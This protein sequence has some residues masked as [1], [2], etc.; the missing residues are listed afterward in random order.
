MLLAVRLSLSFPVLL[1]AIPLYRKDYGYADADERE[2]P[3][4][5]WMSD[6]GITSNFPIHLFDSLLPDRPT[7]GFSLDAFDEKRSTSDPSDPEA[8]VELPSAAGQGLVRPIR[9]F[10]GLG[11]FAAA[12]LNS[13]RNWQDSLQSVLPGYR[14]RIVH[15]A[16]DESEGGLNLSM[17]PELIESLGRYGDIA[18]S[19]LLDFEFSEHRW[20][21]LLSTYSA[22]EQCLEELIEDYE[23]GFADDIAA[24]E[25]KSYK[26]S[27]KRRQ[28]ISSRVESLLGV[29]R[30]WIEDERL[31]DRQ[32]PSPP[33][34]LRAVP[35]EQAGVTDGTLATAAPDDG[36]DASAVPSPS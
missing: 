26:T 20:R 8:R 3:R 29:G 25:E 2:T 24:H 23:G 10:D 35:K 13:A 16:L 18:G 4:L 21:R 34:Y 31:R 36:V 33:V 32:M 9:T 11:G 30:L 5:C 19:R 12:I 17:P 14:E 6:G 1:S 15:V 7:F 28:K 22:F 27:K